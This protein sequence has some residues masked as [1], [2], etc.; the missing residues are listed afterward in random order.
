M[1]NATA[2]V[3][4]R[5]SV[6]CPLTTVAIAA[7]KALVP[8]SAVMVQAR[9]LYEPPLSASAPLN[10]PRLIQVAAPW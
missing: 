4:R 7:A 8:I 10:P 5:T 9:E 6:R 1:K 2:K 3:A